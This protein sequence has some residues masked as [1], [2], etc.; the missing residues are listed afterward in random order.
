[1]AIMKKLNVGKGQGTIVNAGKGVGCGQGH[2]GRKRAGSAAKLGRGQSACAPKKMG[3]GQSALTPSHHNPDADPGSIHPWG[4]A[5]THPSGTDSSGR[6]YQTKRSSS[7]KSNAPGDPAQPVGAGHGKKKV[8]KGQMGMPPMGGAMGADPMAQ[9][10]AAA[11]AAPPLA[12]ER[13][14]LFPGAMSKTKPRKSKP[15]PKKK[16]VIPNTAKSKV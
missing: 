9:L 6:P 10:A 4:G 11:P 13:K 7:V 5:D 1:V 12:A 15:A 16:P 8:G 2:D 3:K 14:P